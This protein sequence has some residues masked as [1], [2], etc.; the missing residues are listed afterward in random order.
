MASFQRSD[1]KGAINT[2][3]TVQIAPP[4]EVVAVV[5]PNLD[6]TLPDLS[7]FKT[8]QILLSN[9]V[10]IDP[11]KRFRLNFLMKAFITW[12]TCGPMLQF[13]GEL[14][15]QLQERTSSFAALRESYYKD[16]I[17][18]KFYLNKIMLLIKEEDLQY[19]IDSNMSND[20]SV[21]PSLTVRAVIDKAINCPGQTSVQLKETLINS[22]LIQ[23]DKGKLKI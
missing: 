4:V 1:S 17:S 6:M 8:L 7:S 20:L 14:K 23:F 9:I 21:I 19:N 11:Y 10:K 5:P 2:R 12:S 13:C 3:K 18:L 16:V 15:Y 22:G